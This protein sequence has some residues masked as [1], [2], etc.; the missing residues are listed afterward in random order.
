MAGYM[1][2]LEAWI[3]EHFFAARP[4][5]NLEYKEDQPRVF[6]WISRTQSSS[7]TS[8]L[9]RLQE[10]LDRLE[11]HDVIWDPYHDK[12]VEHPFYDVSYYSGCLKYMHIVEPYH[13]DRV[14][15]QFGRVQIIPS[16]LLATVRASRGSTAKPYSIAYKYLDTIWE[17]WENLLSSETA[18][19]VLVLHPWD[20]VPGY[21]D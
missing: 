2:L 11:T 19:S 10:D 16:P 4:Y 3:F 20:C 13:P 1:T 7:S 18:R 6:R 9:Q 14:L 12:H 5:L 17:S 21:L 8:I 15:R